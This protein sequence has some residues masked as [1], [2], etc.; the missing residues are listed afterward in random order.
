MRERGLLGELESFSKEMD[1]LLDEQESAPPAPAQEVAPPRPSIPPMVSEKPEQEPEEEP[2]ERWTADVREAA[3]QAVRQVASLTPRKL[4]ETVS[5]VVADTFASELDR[6]GEF[7]RVRY[8]VFSPLNMRSTLGPYHPAFDEPLENVV[9]DELFDVIWRTGQKGDMTSDGPRGIHIVHDQD[10]SGQ[11]MA[12][13][14]SIDGRGSIEQETTEVDL[15]WRVTLPHDGEPEHVAS[16][17]AAASLPIQTFGRAVAEIASLLG[18]PVNQESALTQL[19]FL[20]D[21]LRMSSVKDHGIQPSS[22]T[23]D[24]LLYEFDGRAEFRGRDLKLRLNDSTGFL[25]V[26]ARDLRES[27]IR[28]DLPLTHFSLSLHDRTGSVGLKRRFEP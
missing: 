2:S 7:F 6:D 25:L 12:L 11:E 4:F 28:Y 1:D 16:R 19:F 18:F 14:I 13:D 9:W 26:R 8:F 27:S 21:P 17:L 10:P 3:E 20:L 24:H 22:L 23:R 5:T 15:W